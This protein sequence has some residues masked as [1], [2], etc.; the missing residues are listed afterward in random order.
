MDSMTQLE[1]RVRTL[2]T[3]L[4]RSRLLAFMLGLA[5]VLIT[6]AAQVPEEQEAVT[7]ERLVLISGPDSS[8]VVLVAGPESSLV[9]QTPAGEEVLRLG[10]RP[11]REIQAIGVGPVDASRIV[12]NATESRSKGFSVFIRYL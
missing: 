2:E 12:S 4:G 5:V 10:G 6:G 7:T 1:A 9:I 11:L 8:S 3:S